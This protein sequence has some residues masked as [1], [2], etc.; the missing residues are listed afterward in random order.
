MYELSIIVV[1]VIVIIVITTTIIAVG[2]TYVSQPQ[3]TQEEKDVPSIVTVYS[4]DNLSVLSLTDLTAKHTINING[5]MYMASDTGGSISRVIVDERENFEQ[6][7]KAADIYYTT[8]RAIEIPDLPP[9]AGSFNK[10]LKF[11]NVSPEYVFGTELGDL[12]LGLPD[13]LIEST[14]KRVKLFA[15]GG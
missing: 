11:I 14:L 2:Y 4:I 7:L 13:E 15:E 5:L 12:I 8:S 3:P 1:I 9:V 6:A 10:L